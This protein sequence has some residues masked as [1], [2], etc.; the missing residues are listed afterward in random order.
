MYNN[1]SSSFEFTADVILNFCLLIN[2]KPKAV[3]FLGAYS[4]WLI[5]LFLLLKESVVFVLTV[6]LV[7][8]LVVLLILVLVILLFFVLLIFMAVLLIVILVEVHFNTSLI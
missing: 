3:C 5:T 4:F 7:L 8:V 1:I 2:I 6:L